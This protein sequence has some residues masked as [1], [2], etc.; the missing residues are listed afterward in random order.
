MPKTWTDAAEK[1][2]YYR[3]WWASEK[4]HALR[5]SVLL[6][7]SMKE[8]RFPSKASIAKYNIS[9]EELLPILESLKTN[10]N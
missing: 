7:K 2:A 1:R 9:R 4:G 6:R 5:K 10:Q 3:D 8:R